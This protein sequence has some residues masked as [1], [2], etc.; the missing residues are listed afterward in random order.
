MK[1]ENSKMKIFG[2]PMDDQTRCVHYNT[3][4]DIIA[5]KFKCCEQYYPCYSCHEETANH[6]AQRWPQNQWDVKA[7]LCGNCR[8]ELSI[9]EYMNSNNRCPRCNAYFN[10]NCS[11]HYH[12]YFQMD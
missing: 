8:S 3:V 9:T 7:I 10:P 6:K 1:L 4:N 11:N 12:L 2:K 5:I